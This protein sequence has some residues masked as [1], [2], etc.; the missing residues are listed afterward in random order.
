MSN[1]SNFEAEVS[2]RWQIKRE[3]F[4]ELKEAQGTLQAAAQIRREI[5]MEMID[6]AQSLDEIRPILKLLVGQ[7]R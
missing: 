1:N 4:L 2:Q 5:Y 7:L 3:R 6:Q